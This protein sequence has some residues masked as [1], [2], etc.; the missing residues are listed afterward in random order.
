MPSESSRCVDELLPK[1]AKIDEFV[2]KLDSTKNHDDLL[3]E[4]R[5]LVSNTQSFLD[6]NKSLIPAYF[7]KK[8]TD[9]LKR[10]EKRVDEPQKTQFQIKFK[11][12]SKKLD[13][14]PAIED[15]APVCN[16]AAGSC[17][18]KF[19]PDKLGFQGIKNQ[20]IFL[21]PDEV[22]FKDVNLI[23]LENCRVNVDGLVNTVYI[24]DLKNTT[25]TVLLACR[26]I[27]VVNCSNCCFTLACQQL[28]IDSTNSSEFSIFTSARSMLESSQNLKFRCID[29]KTALG[30]SK[31]QADTIRDLL[32]RANFD[33][34]KNNWKCIDDFDWLLPNVPS[35]NYE[36][37]MD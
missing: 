19:L 31:V 3:D 7:F 12:S 33:E 2:D 28:R 20:S 4:A 16:S 17:A 23:D 26:A 10:L 34:T 11:P 9:S 15:K 22:E 29:F 5:I 13:D 36:L 6:K 21:G 8:V 27:T 30:E 37:I 32:E 1:L 18:T 24:R 25:V 14:K 35:K